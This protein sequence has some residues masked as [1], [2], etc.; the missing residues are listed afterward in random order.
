MRGALLGTLLVCGCTRAARVDPPRA[1][2]RAPAPEAPA[3]AADDGWALE[4]RTPALPADEQTRDAREGELA[5]A[6]GG[7]DA[8]L[9]HV[10]RAIAEARARGQ[11]A[12]EVD[13]L[14]A[15]LRRVGDPH[16]RPRL[17][18]ASGRAPVDVA[19][20]R[21][22][23]ADR[24]A[25]PSRCGAA[26]AS[27][28]AGTEILV[29]LRTDALADLA[30]VPT[31]ARTGE[32][33]TLE[34][35]LKVPARSAKLVVLGPRG[36]P[37]T[38]P[39]SLDPATGVVR[40]RF[41][42]D[43]PGAFSAQLLADV[44]TGPRPLLEASVFADVSPAPPGEDPPAPG[45][46]AGSGAPE[47]EALLRMLLA[48]RTEEGVPSLARMPA[49]DAL[50]R[51]HAERMRERHEVA[52]DLGSG[53]FL[54]RFEAA[55]PFPA[56]AVGENVAHASSVRLAHRALHASASHRLN[57]LRADYTHVGIGVT[58]AADGSVYVCETFASA[59]R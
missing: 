57:L 33:L 39:T 43:Q 7:E 28:G 38:F 29:V 4:T 44:G 23:L 54:A 13:A 51:A 21:A 19:K 48:L 30:P 8:A 40:A 22:Q 55:A 50:A 26:L 9:T 2:A 45:E 42:L 53:D 34:A 25:E 16:V 10:A 58:H 47:D 11:A 41:V 5:E 37:R 32:W 14:V 46:E 1:P 15:I 36:A 52:H 56:R 24:S 6:C 59:T 20:V 18:I 49:L 3:P 31:H 27:A 12:P 17:V 35:R